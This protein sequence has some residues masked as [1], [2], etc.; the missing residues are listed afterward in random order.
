MYKTVLVNQV[1]GPLFIDIVNAK[2]RDSSVVLLTGAI[3][4]AGTDIDSSVDVIFL[5]GYRKANMRTR[6]ISWLMFTAQVSI[7]LWKNRKG[8]G[9]ILLVTNPPL[10]PFL[11]SF[12]FL[13]RVKK[14]ILVYDIY[15]DILVQEN[16]LAE[17]N[18]LTKL[19]YWL[20]KRGFRKTNVVYTI[21]N[22][23]SENLVRNYQLSNIQVIPPWVDSKFMKPIPKSQN[24]FLKNELSHIDK[25]IVLYS[26][27]MGETHD[28]KTLIEAFNDTRVSN[29]F[30]LLFVGGGFQRKRLEELARANASISFLDYQ[31]PEMLPFTFS[32]ADIFYVSLGAG[33]GDFSIPSKTF[34]AMAS[35]LPILAVCD[36]SSDLKRIVD[37]NKL[38]CA[39]VPGDVKGLKNFLIR[40]NSN[41]LKA[42]S[43]NSLHLSKSYTPA[44]AELFRSIP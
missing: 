19:W 25:K 30:H 41:E 13:E 21:S 36:N 18:P 27:N 40:T 8:I 37:D 44:N 35:G 2:N 26:G 34:Y 11:S 38:G 22:K 31:P 3:E 9:E 12:H 23:M 14:S 1:T 10:M 29:T 7:Y 6:V 20:N 24:I 39:F 4:K 17:K 5:P 33:V 42:M 32:S 16:Y 15:P 28:F 43:D